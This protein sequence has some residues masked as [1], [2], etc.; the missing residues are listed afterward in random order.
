MKHTIKFIV[1][2]AGLF[3][4]YQALAIEIIWS[5]SGLKM[6]ESVEYD[7]VRDQ[8]YVSNINAGVMEQDGNGSIG[9]IDGNGKLVNVDWVTGLHSPK[10]LALHNNKLYVADVKQLV[11]INVESGQLIAHYEANNSKVLNGIA[12]DKTGKVFVSDWIGNRIYTLEDG[13]LKIWLESSE[14]NSPNGLWVDHEYLYVASWGRNPKDDFSTETSGNIKKISR[15]NKKLETLEQEGL[16]INMDGISSYSD[17]K[18]LVSDFLKGIIY[19]IN[20]EGHIEKSLKSK[21]GSA[22]FYYIREKN[23]LVVPLMMD[24]KVVA[25][26][27]D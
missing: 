6:P 23:L 11:V 18:W 10:G 25:Y 12:I 9:L 5:V 4:S 15:S 8:Y 26:T 1:T 16:W 2:I 21:K 20:N 19:L 3:F 17:N 27:L 22:D 13:E 24:N 7:S 14:L